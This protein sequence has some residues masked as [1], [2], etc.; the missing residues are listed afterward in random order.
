MTKEQF[1]KF[2]AANYPETLPINYL[3]KQN[4]KSRWLHPQ[5]WLEML[6]L[7]LA[8]STDQDEININLLYC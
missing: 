2:W 1:Q 7:Y 6:I 8:P 3:F 4:L 5:Q